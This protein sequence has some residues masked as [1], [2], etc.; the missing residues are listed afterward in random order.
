M[1]L[2]LLLFVVA[3]L[4]RLLPIK[5]VMLAGRIQFF[6]SDAYYHMRRIVYSWAHFPD[7]LDFDPYINFP[8]GAR[9]IWTPL[10]DWCIAALFWPLFEHIGQRQLE[11]LASLIP[12]LL[13]GF[14]VVALYF[15]ARK[16]FGL[17]VA[18]VAGLV[19]SVLPGH[20]YYSQVGYVDH[21]CAVAWVTT[22]L[23]GAGMTALDTICRGPNGIRETLPSALS[24]G[25]ALALSLLVW[26]GALLHVGLVEVGLLT[27]LLSRPRRDDAVLTAGTLAVIHATAFGIVAPFSIGSAW[28][29]WSDF[30]PV[31]LTNFQPWFFASAALFCLIC[32]WVWKEKPSLGGSI[33]LRSVSAAGIGLAI[34]A[35]CSLL[36]PTL[37]D[38][39]IEAWA[40]LS[41]TDSFQSM[42]S[43]SESLFGAA[44]AFGIAEATA[45]L[46]WFFLAVPVALVGV[47]IGASR[48]DNR[49]A[50]FLYLWWTLCLCLVT[51][52]QRR[53]MNSSAV[54]VALLLALALHGVYELCSRYRA[55]LPAR[56]LIRAVLLVA[57]LGVLYPALGVYLP[58][59]SDLSRTDNRVLLRG[60]LH[61]WHAMGETARWLR[62]NTP[63]TSGWLDP[64]RQPEYGIV[65]P[66]D[67]GHVIEYVARR[68][69]SSDNFGDDIGARNFLL[70]Q[71]YYGS[72]ES[73]A[74]QILDQLQARYV[75]VPFFDSFLIDRPGRASMYRTLY[76]HDGSEFVP[77]DDRA[78]GRVP[79]SQRHR[80]VY[81]YANRKPG[82]EVHSVFKV[83]EYV[84]GARIVGRAA[85]GAEIRASLAVMT[86]GQRL[87]LYETRAAAGPDGRY[88]L[89]VPYANSPGRSA[90]DTDTHYVLQCA[91]EQIE[92]AIEEAEVRRGA[93]VHG[94][95]LC[96]D[97]R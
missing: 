64:T 23:L 71:E 18:L 54:A 40:W 1:V 66:W 46:S 83:F 75:V 31:V 55:G 96:L 26:P 30:S 72:G 86:A 42:V 80:L 8:D 28:A 70:V 11:L 52:L 19:L 9:S 35:L 84:R 49:A 77:R 15:L 48:R 93:V 95:N 69:T 14:T 97:P 63:R 74:V 32:A 68:P 59:V 34:V 57:T 16:H 37:F 92:I 56:F 2:P 76:E 62:Q 91:G 36:W 4:V 47:A 38:G 82:G 6:G 33:P 53:F 58:F 13:G 50:V 81:E 87:F 44:G 41:K 27:L 43:E 29:Q 7:V 21:H 12:P 24:L 25:S 60:S 67:I 51:V 61:E 89:R 90:V 39:V 79:A 17:G 45:H 3:V 5:N 78:E 10:F 85:P 20:F 22:L 94:P 88:R 65:S 73:R